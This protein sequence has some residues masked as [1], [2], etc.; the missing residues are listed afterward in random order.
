MIHVLC[1]KGMFASAFFM[2]VIGHTYHASRRS[3]L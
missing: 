1:E 3:E 2:Y